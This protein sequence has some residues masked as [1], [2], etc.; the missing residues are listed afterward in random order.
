[1]PCDRLTKEDDMTTFPAA[2]VEGL[3]VSYREAGN[4]ANP[5]LLLLRG[6]P[7]SSR[8]FRT[9]LPALAAI[10]STAAWDG[11]CHAL[12][13]DRSAE[14]EA[15]PDRQPPTVII[16]GRGDNSFAPEGGEAYLR[17]LPDAE[18]IR[19]Y[20][21]HFAVQDN[22]DSIAGAIAAFHERRTADTFTATR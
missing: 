6:F 13:I 17:D 11:V 1:L 7:S 14:T 19:L 9:L 2:R 10:G 3:D 5:K 12:W 16:S 21:G 18:L 15:P 8:Q 22:L 4:P 20:S